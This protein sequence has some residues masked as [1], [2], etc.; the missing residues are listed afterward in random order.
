VADSERKISSDIETYWTNYAQ[1]G[2]P[3]GAGL[4]ARPRFDVK[5][6]RYLEFTGG[7]PVAKENLRGSFCRLWTGF[8]KRRLE[9]Q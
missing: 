3:N 4:A 7:G 8:L 1:T 2:N 9:T 6:R 5:A